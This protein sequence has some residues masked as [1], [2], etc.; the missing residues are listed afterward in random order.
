VPSAH[1]WLGIRDPGADDWPPLHSDRFD[2]NESA[3]APGA[4]ALAAS[5][6]ALIEEARS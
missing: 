6:V 3:L 5:A 2:I 4:A 1:F